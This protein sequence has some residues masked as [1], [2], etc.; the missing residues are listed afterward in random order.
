MSA[1]EPILEATRAEVTRRRASVPVERLPERPG[2]VRPFARVLADA[3]GVS[4]IAEHKR[5]SPS[6]GVI[7]EG[8]SIEDVVCA[9]ERGGARAL[10]VLTDGPSFGGSLD[11]LRAARAASALPVLRKD[12]VVDRYQLHESLAAGADAILLIVA[13]LD[14]ADLKF[15]Y[16][17]ARSFGLGVLVEVHDGHELAIAATIEPA[18]I[19]INNRDL[20][21]LQVDTARTLELIPSLPAETVI[22]SESGLRTAEDVAT[23]VAAGVDAVLVGEALMR[24]GDIEAACRALTG[25]AAPAPTMD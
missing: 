23:V 16:D 6:A 18:V 19:G 15:L 11:D 20:A 13:A 5:R 14:P 7:R 2:D 24:S 1:L 10:S 21:T 17:Q 12:F 3:P 22:V 8:A 4:V 25:V 9:Y